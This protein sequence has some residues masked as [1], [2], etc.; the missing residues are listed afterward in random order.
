MLST[1]SSA[2]ADVQQMSEFALTSAVVFT[3]D[4][5]TPPGFCFLHLQISSPVILS[6]SE[7]PA[8]LSGTITF[9]FGEIMDAVSAIKFTPQKSMILASVRPAS[10]E[11][12]SESPRKS[13]I[14]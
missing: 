9:L 10:W 7:H 4:T 12:P 2:F 3:Y 6:A 11:S 1:T 13:L 14:S 5:T 8:L